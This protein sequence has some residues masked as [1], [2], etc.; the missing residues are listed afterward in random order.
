MDGQRLRDTQPQEILANPS[1]APDQIELG[2]LTLQQLGK[3]VGDSVRAGTGPTARTLKI[4]GTVTLP[5]IGV[6]LSDHVSLG[7]GAMVAESTLLSVLDLS[8]VAREQDPEAISALPSTLGARPET[9]NRRRLRRRSAES[10]RGH[11]GRS[12]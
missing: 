6:M 5:S 10:L 4:V 2:A 1:L 12:G 8:S 3:S 11:P 9:R 7:R